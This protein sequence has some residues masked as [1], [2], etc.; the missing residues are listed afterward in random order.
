[1]QPPL[2]RLRVPT[3]WR[4]NYNDFREIAPAGDRDGLK[5]DLFQAY[6]AN[7]NRLLDLGWYPNGDP[8]GGFRIEVYV[9]DFGGERL[10]SVSSADRAWIVVELERLLASIARS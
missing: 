5:E 6:H 7:T 8:S 10:H 4:V 3:G 9:G 1:M 2:L